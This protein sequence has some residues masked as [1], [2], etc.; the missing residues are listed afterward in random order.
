MDFA[1]E[2]LLR[3]SARAS[4]ENL[5]MRTWQLSNEFALHHWQDDPDAAEMVAE[6]LPTDLVGDY[7]MVRA[8]VA[9]NLGLINEAAVAYAQLLDLGE[10]TDTLVRSDVAWANLCF[11]QPTQEALEHLAERLSRWLGRG[12]HDVSSTDAALITAAAMVGYTADVGTQTPNR[13]RIEL[14]I[15]LAEAY[16]SNNPTPTDRLLWQAQQAHGAGDN[17][18]AKELARR[19]IEIAEEK[20]D[21]VAE[22]EGHDMLG[23][24]ALME[25]DEPE[26]A[27]HFSQCYQIVA[28]HEAPIIAVQRAAT[29]AWAGFSAGQVEF[30]AELA[31]AALGACD[32]MPA[33]P[34][35]RDLLTVLGNCALERGDAEEAALWAER[36]RELR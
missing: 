22:Y 29:A 18:R 28:Q 12:F 6:Q 2:P 36:I 31:T 11:L 35:H 7:W 32:R 21:A 13:E 3:A 8:T 14:Y 25:V 24:L 9:E 4:A 20:G 30:A 19:V 17:V 27:L 15:N 26:V 1:L 5:T 10:R 33:G 34:V 23:N 16:G